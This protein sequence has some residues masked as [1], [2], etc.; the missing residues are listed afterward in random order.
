LETDI[1]YKK[2]ELPLP[3]AVLLLVHG[4][5][6]YTDRWMFLAD[7]FSGNNISSYALQLRGFGLTN[8]LRGHVDSFDVY[9]NDIL[10]LHQ[11]IKKEIPGKKLFLSG[12]SAGALLVILTVIMQPKIFD[13]IICLSPAF[14]NRLHFSF[15]ERLKIYSSMLVNPR[16]QF[17][18]PFNAQMCTRDPDYQKIIEQEPREHRLASA[19]FL[20]ETLKAQESAK[21]L[22]AKINLPVL[23]L[24]AGEDKIV[25]P[26]VSKRFFQGLKTKDKDLIEYPD[27]YHS[28]SVEL[29]REKVFADILSWI[30]K[31]L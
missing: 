22:I 24:L 30:E 27:M 20:F 26:E 12:E 16:R 15:L 7:F 3:K 21:S 25:D 9:I 11:I 1:I 19:R 14:G 5:G 4:L 10:S 17:S 2:W 31:R 6:A 13:G 29:G 18:M 28:L 23:F 8:D